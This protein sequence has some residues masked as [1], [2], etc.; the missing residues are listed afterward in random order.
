MR[1]SGPGGLFILEPGL[2]FLNHGSFGARPRELLEEQDRFRRMAEAEPVRF[3]ARSSGALIEAALGA[4]AAYLGA[5]PRDLAFVENAT[6]AVGIAA[7]SLALEP[8][9][10]VIGTDHEY[11]AC[12]EA[13][14][15][16]CEARGASYRSIA[17]PLPYAGHGDFLAR[18][19]G[20]IGPR[21]RA[22]FVSQ[23][24][25]PT[26]LELPAA[27]VCALAR[28]LGL[29]SVIDGAHVPG[30]LELELGKLGA[31][32]YAGNCHKWLCAPLGSA[33]LY[34]REGLHEGVVPPVVSWGLVDEANG[35][36]FHEAYAGSFPLARRLRWLGTRDISAFLA[37]PA[38][39]DFCRRQADEARKCA[40][41]AA[42]TARR[43]AALLGLESL[44]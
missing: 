36:D 13:W 35:T 17:V 2:V 1:R 24:T 7:R 32:F 18:L 44:A 43:A 37:V 40:T 16:V 26:A 19:E 21:T 15:R 27:E 38:A 41:L 42:E 22:L 5:S 34:V 14:R 6:T 8:G 9:D 25:S 29:V 28:R 3:L 11:G 12:A 20:A 10:E 23:I 31:D 39:I 33:F 4:L 30:Q